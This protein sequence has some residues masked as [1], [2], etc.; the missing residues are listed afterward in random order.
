MEKFGETNE[1]DIYKHKKWDAYRDEIDEQTEI[2]FHQSPIYER[3]QLFVFPSPDNTESINIEDFL[4]HIGEEM[5][6][7][8]TKK[9]K[10]CI[11]CV[12]PK[13]YEKE[14]NGLIS[15]LLEE[16]LAQREAIEAAEKEIITVT[17]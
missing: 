10:G 9:H 3:Y 16:Y 5:I 6:K 2:Q 14:V 15:K 7:T 8:Y 1:R 17:A 4:N 12:S 11:G 13:A